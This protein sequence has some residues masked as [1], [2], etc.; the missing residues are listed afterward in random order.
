METK[1]LTLQNVAGVITAGSVLPVVTSVNSIT[2]YPIS[3]TIKNKLIAGSF[4]AIVF[5]VELAIQVGTASCSMTGHTCTI[6]S[7]QNVT[8]TVAST[9][10]AGSALSVTVN[11]V[12]NAN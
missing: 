8:I 1:T 11:K 2:N 10:N 3:F 7:S 4:I 9:I 12:K 6:V 5:P